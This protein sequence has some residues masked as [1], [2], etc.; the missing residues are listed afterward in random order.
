MALIGSVSG[1]YLSTFVVWCFLAPNYRL[2]ILLEP[3]V[4]SEFY[5]GDGDIK[6]SLPSLPF[7]FWL[8]TVMCF[9]VAYSLSLCMLLK[10][11]GCCCS[12]SPWVMNIPPFKPFR[13]LVMSSVAEA[14]GWRYLP[15]AYSS[16]SSWWMLCKSR[17]FVLCIAP[18]T[19]GLSFAPNREF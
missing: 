6:L 9:K 12:W 14:W 4:I 10:P 3:P 2:A 18:L 19:G 8:K 7:Y 5:I 17:W 1:K 13:V 15:A 11:C 16:S